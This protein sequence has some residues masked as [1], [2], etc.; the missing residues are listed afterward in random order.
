MIIR[1]ILVEKYIPTLLE[2]LQKKTDELMETQL[3]MNSLS[4][5]EGSKIEG[6][7]VSSV[8]LNNET[9]HIVDLLSDIVLFYYNKGE[10]DNKK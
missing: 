8:E 1:N 4:N 6:V 3:L 5:I 2:E 10:K 7:E 9:E